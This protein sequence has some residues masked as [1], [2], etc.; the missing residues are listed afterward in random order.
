MKKWIIRWNSGFGDS[1]EVYEA[2]SKEE[3]DKI[4]CDCWHDEVESNADYEAIEY[5]EENAEEC[6]LE[7]EE[8]DH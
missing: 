5:T 1:Y 4:A 7:W 3:A 8:D 2:N 6:G